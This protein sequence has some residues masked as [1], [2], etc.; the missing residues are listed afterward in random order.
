MQKRRNLRILSRLVKG[1]NFSTKVHFLERNF[2][3][4]KASKWISKATNSQFKQIY[5]KADRGKTWKVTPKAW[6]IWKTTQSNI[7]RASQNGPWESSTFTSRSS[8]TSIYCWLFWFSN[9]NVLI[10][11]AGWKWNLGF[12]VYCLFS[13]EGRKFLNKWFWSRYYLRIVK[14]WHINFLCKPITQG[15]FGINWV[16]S[17]LRRFSQTFTFIVLFWFY[18][19]QLM[20]RSLVNVKVINLFLVVMFL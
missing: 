18:K 10:L 4:N 17:H 13:W 20:F 12:W 16:I 2:Q 6:E 19:N 14:I 3:S 9:K 5:W 7:D 15:R 11:C 8:L 1:S